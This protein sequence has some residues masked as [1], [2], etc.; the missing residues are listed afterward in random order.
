MNRYIT[1]I[2]RHFVGKK[3]PESIINSVCHFRTGHQSESTCVIKYSR[4]C[5]LLLTLL[6]FAHENSLNS[7]KC[8]RTLMFSTLVLL[9]STK[10]ISLR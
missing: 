4:C 8:G 2:C 5:G 9:N 1:D 3:C 10:Q 6:D 7:G